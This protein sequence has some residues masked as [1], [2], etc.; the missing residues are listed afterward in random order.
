MQVCVCVIADLHTHSM[1]SI[2]ASRAPEYVCQCMYIPERFFLQGCLG[3]VSYSTQTR[4]SLRVQ[5]DIYV[6]S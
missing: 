1:H 5:D 4:Q 3:R 2:C 6:E